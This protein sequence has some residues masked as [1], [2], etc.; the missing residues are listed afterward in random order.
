MATE[1][2][3]SVDICNAISHFCSL[4]LRFDRKLRRDNP[5][6]ILINL[7]A[8]LLSLN[9]LFL[10][11][12]WLCSFANGGLSVATAALQHYLLLATF[13]WMGLEAV[14]MYLALIKVFNT[15][16]SSCLLKFCAVGWGEAWSRLQWIHWML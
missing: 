8:A 7:S 16:I 5:S 13:M 14:H 2:I 4:P 11:N 9:L 3:Y 6:K 10:L 12:C 15:Y 1:Q